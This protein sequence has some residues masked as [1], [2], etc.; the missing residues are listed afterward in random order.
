MRATVKTITRKWAEC[1]DD[2]RLS[3]AVA[4]DYLRELAATMSTDISKWNLIGL[5]TGGA[6]DVMLI[7]DKREINRIFLTERKRLA[8]AAPVPTRAGHPDSES[9]APSE[10]RV[11]FDSE[12]LQ[13][14]VSTIDDQVVEVRK[15]L[16]GQSMHRLQLNIEDM[17]RC[18]QLEVASNIAL[19]VE[20][21]RLANS[22][23]SI[24][25]SARL[26]REI[27]E[28]LAGDFWHDARIEGN[29]IFIATKA[30]II[31]AERNVAAGINRS[32]DFG[33]LI[34]RYDLAEGSVRVLP[35]KG[36]KRVRDYYHPHVGSGGDVCWG[37]GSNVAATA[38]A[39]QH[40][41]T[42]FDLL[43]SVLTHYNSGGPYFPLYDADSARA[44]GRIGDAYLSPHATEERA[45]AVP[46][47]A[48]PVGRVA[49]GAPSP[50]GNPFVPA[51]FFV[52]PNP[53]TFVA[54]G[55]A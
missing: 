15:R 27:R 18:T 34:V 49:Q 4:L 8:E 9:D 47:P 13:K 14:L 17:A 23:A 46:A 26:D 35:Y 43:Y 28:V 42:L 37:D 11:E 52:V 25:H 5:F 21:S 50:T 41:K 12:A 32:I 39:G 53:T 16:I 29:A 36:N 33:Y 38:L 3:N 7:T 51:D 30:P 6:D 40:V 22:E 20:L 1:T 24:E 44:Y 19:N 55:G 2:V 54:P 31:L 48:I 45:R 10:I